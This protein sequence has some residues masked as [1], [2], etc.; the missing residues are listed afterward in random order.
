MA[1]PFSTN[2]L[3]LRSDRIAFGKTPPDL[4]ERTEQTLILPDVTG[5]KLF[6]GLSTLVSTSGIT[7]TLEA[8]YPQNA[9]FTFD[10]LNK[11]FGIN[12]STPLYAI[13]ISSTT[14][15]RLQGGTLIANASGLVSVPT[16]ALFST[17]PAYV[18][19]PG[20]IPP[21][22][23]ASTGS[24]ILGISVPTSALYGSLPSLL[25]A[26][27][28]IPLL[29]L[30]S[31]GVI[32]A[33]SFVGDGYYL[34]NIPL[35]NING[36]VTGDFFR[37]NSIPLSTLA[38][39]GQIWIRNQE[40]AVYAPIISTSQLQLSSLTGNNI[41]TL[42]IAA[43][44]LI[45]SSIQ[46][47]KFTSITFNTSNIS[48]ISVVTNT[49]QAL[50]SVSTGLFYG[51]GQYIRNI[52][53]SNLSGIIPRSNFGNQTIP[54][55]AINPYGDWSWVY[56]TITLTQNAP[57][58]SYGDI[59]ASSFHG[60]Y[61]I[62]DGSLLSNIDAIPLASLR[63]TV[64]GLGTA[65]YIS[66]LSLYS[67]IRGL[68]T[69]GYISSS[70]L[71]STTKGL[72]EYVSSFIDTG[73]LISSILPFISSSYFTTQLT[74]TVQGLGT[75]GYVSTASLYSTIDGLGTSG[76]ISSLSLTSSIDGL[77]T[78]G[79]I[80]SLSLT[81]SIDGLGTSGYVSS[82]SL[83]SSIEGLGTL[84]YISS[85]SLT[86]SIDGLGTLGYISSSQLVSTTKGL[87][88]YVSSFI[89][90]GELISSILPFISSSYFTTQLT[91]TVQGL[92]TSGYVSSLSLVS[93]LD[94]IG[95]L[96]YISSS[97]LLSTTSQYA[98]E[99]R[100]STL[101][102]SNIQNSVLS[103]QAIYT[104]SIVGNYATLENEL[105]AN[106]VR[107]KDVTASTSVSILDG[108]LLIQNSSGT[109]PYTIYL[110]S[111][112]RDLQTQYLIN[113]V[114]QWDLRVL[115][116][117]GNYVFNNFLGVD[118][119]NLTRAGQV[120]ILCNAPSYTMDVNGDIHASGIF[121]GNG[122]GL[123]NLN[124]ISSLSLT[125]TVEGLGTA[126]YVSTA[127][128]YSSINSAL[129]S[130]ST[131]IG[132]GG[133]NML[134][135]ISTVEGLGTAGYVSTASLYS[136][137][138]GSLSSFST[139]IGPGGTNMLTII[140]TVEGLGTAGYISSS[141]LLSTTKGLQDYIS[142]FIDPTELASTVVGIGSAGFISSIGFDVKLASTV[143]GLGTSGYVSTSSL[144]YALS[145]FSTAIGPGGTNM[146]TIMSTVAGLGTAGYVS[147][148]SLYSSIAG[149]GSIG[150]ISTF[151]LQSTVVGLGTSGYVS[152]P[153]LYSSITGLGS[154]GYISTASL[155]STVGGLGSIGYISTLN[156]V[157]FI[158]AQQIIAS[159]IYATLAGPTTVVLY[160]F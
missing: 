94:G 54:I 128:L 117:N 86:S 106:V 129:S 152:T 92:G 103:T 21:E 7:G 14:G 41:S 88:E 37:P 45:A 81:S 2:E 69:V 42:R 150:Y 34:S 63:S 47:D 131:A 11:R 84:G 97:Q 71:L 121:Y 28:S 147:T 23:I 153:S 113:D 68:G 25:F 36:T 57:L 1:E 139:A 17:L 90:T 29:A 135:I 132:P 6:F 39:T 75:S 76:Y 134:T 141:Q 13:D 115:Q 20:S 95:T 136:S 66:S 105:V 67:T 49:F 130:F 48:T 10:N 107:A 114:D 142:T 120:G 65:G 50:Q 9:S 74:S 133:T 144:N 156:T 19:A 99:F 43:G 55:N 16:A 51:D 157:P 44:S 100:T 31:S 159:S 127:S 59:T 104:S 64:I 91:S 15:I 111:H 79:Y 123:Y 101:V 46:A 30:Q 137:I 56:G 108:G 138:N 82:L 149:L 78:S 62:G 52:S 12:L 160:E 35:A 72:E 77:G 53:T 26:P 73:E 58:I 151:S 140:S 102:A 118:V 148:L 110:E 27:S 145:T 109:V 87:E 124:A 119:L 154:I 70:Q 83:I 155:V 112:G 89:D 146:L 125:S 60:G 126:G 4:P 85:L 40:G 143:Q 116:T 98:T 80:S 24:A 8:I 22:A 38:S 3:F 61:F 32:I 5:S 93:T 33:S 96:G 122:S 18:F 158:S